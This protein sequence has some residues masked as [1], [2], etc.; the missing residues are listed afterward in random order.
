MKELNKKILNEF[1]ENYKDIKLDF[2][3]KKENDIRNGIYE[4]IY[5]KEKIN[6]SKEK[7]ET[8]NEYITNLFDLSNIQ[9]VLKD[10]NGEINIEL[11]NLLQ[12]YLSKTD[13]LSKFWITKFKAGMQG[14]YGLLIVE[15]KDKNSYSRPELIPVKVIFENSFDNQVFESLLSFEETTYSNKELIYFLQRHYLI[16]NN[17]VQVT[18]KLIDY[19]TNSLI[20]SDKISNLIK[21]N[22]DLKKKNL[23]FDFI[24]LSILK[25]DITGKPRCEK[26]K[27][28]LEM[29]D[30][31][32]EVI[33]ILPHWEKGSIIFNGNSVEPQNKPQQLYEFMKGILLD[34]MIQMKPI[35]IE[36]IPSNL[37]ENIINWNPTSILKVVRKTRNDIYE[38]IKLDLGFPVDE[39]TEPN[40][41]DYNSIFLNNPNIKR[42]LRLIKLFLIDMA[43]KFL[44]IL[45]K[46]NIQETFPD[47]DLK[48]IEINVNLGINE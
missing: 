44:S 3:S 12:T 38:E 20:K 34:G 26:V 5:G 28:K 1:N 15:I 23:E 29:L 33:A 46:S 16:K 45:Q 21:Q 32:D 36:G 6:S 24:P 25:N 31:F 4:I 2:N 11:Q 27:S 39:I 42:E 17:K 41:N 40:K 48:Q 35:E 47:I 19:K 22:L 43:Y 7:E 9:W 30:K 18:S 37:N 13:F 8:L 10:K 14:K